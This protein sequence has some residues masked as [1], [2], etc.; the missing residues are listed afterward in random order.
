M[1]KTIKISTNVYCFKNN[2]EF[3]WQFLRVL[4]YKATFLLYGKD[5][6]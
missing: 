6:P 5:Q 4:K 2:L 1:V 3:I